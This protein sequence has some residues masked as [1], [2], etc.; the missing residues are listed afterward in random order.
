M[1]IK[2]HWDEEKKCVPTF[3]GLS[4]GEMFVSAN[5]DLC[6]K[7][8]PIYIADDIHCEC[9]NEHDICDSEEIDSPTYNAYCVMCGNY[10]ELLDEAE[11]TLIDV[12]ITLIQKGQRI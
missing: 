4:V 6:I 10:I 1:A 9:D 7:T 12:E 3:G 5:G 8:A 2:L 11:I